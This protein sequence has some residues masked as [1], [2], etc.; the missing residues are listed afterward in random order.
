MDDLF[1]GRSEVVKFAFSNIKVQH[2]YL[3]HTVRLRLTVFRPK[4]TTYVGLQKA[5]L[6]KVFWSFHN[7]NIRQ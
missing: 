7:H 5:H 4:D 6:N 3:L 2:L 1:L